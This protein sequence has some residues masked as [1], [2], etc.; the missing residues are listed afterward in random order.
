MLPFG[1]AHLAPEAISAY[2]SP[3]PFCVEVVM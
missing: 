2:V 3:L 1:G